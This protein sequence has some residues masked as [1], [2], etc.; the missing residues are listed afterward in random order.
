[1]S[2]LVALLLVSGALF[3][4]LAA[5]GLVRLPDLY[6]RMSATSKAATL[7]VSLILL[8]AAVHFGT[9]AV[10]GRAVVIV[11]FLFLTAPLAAHAIGRAGYR[12]RSPLWEG[13]VADELAG[14]EEASRGAM[15]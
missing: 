9:A 6:T 1:M 10:A 3:M 2:A 14:A 13:T 4:L 5:V 7:G 11:T 12:R 8:G 15:A